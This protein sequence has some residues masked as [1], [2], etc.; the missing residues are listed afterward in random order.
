[1]LL[2]RPH[3][4]QKRR[5]DQTGLRSVMTVPPSVQLRGSN[6]RGGI[7]TVYHHRTDTIITCQNRVRDKISRFSRSFKLLCT[8]ITVLH[9]LIPCIHAAQEINLGTTLVALKYEG[10]VVV[11]ADSRTSQ[12]V[13]VSNKFARKIN[14]V[15]NGENGGMTCAICRSGSAA[16]TQY[17]VKAAKEDF[18]SRRWR[19]QFRHPTVSQVAHFL[20][21]TMRSSSSRQGLQASMICAGC[22]DGGGHI[23][24]IAIDGGALWEEDVFCVSGSGSTFLIGY[25]DALR[26]DKLELYSKARAIELVAKLLKL[27]IARDGASGG[28]IR[29]MVL[30]KGGI[31]EH[32][33]YPDAISSTASLPGFA[34]PSKLP[35]GGEVATS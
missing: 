6:G 17:L 26:L 16:D 21:S 33:I 25:L 8:A 5:V 3:I 22:D 23:F 2:W 31:E 11:G 4:L 35:H 32:T 1:M 14:I 9:F 24:A 13:M 7:P 30:R 12:S 15:V 27:S 10:G 18:R 20:R 19:D 29:I 28:L 34:D